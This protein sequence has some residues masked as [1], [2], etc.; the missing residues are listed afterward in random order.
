M[1]SFRKELEPE[2][3]RVFI[4]LVKYQSFGDPVT[5]SDFQTSYPKIVYKLQFVAIRKNSYSLARVRWDR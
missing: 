2:I 5:S 3:E 1:N 4:T